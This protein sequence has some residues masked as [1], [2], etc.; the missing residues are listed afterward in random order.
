MDINAFLQRAQSARQ[1]PTLYLLGKGDYHPNASADRPGSRVDPASELALIQRQRPHIHAEYVKAMQKAG[2]ALEDLPREA[3]D[4]SGFVCW[5]LKIVRSTGPWTGGWIDTNNIHRD[6]RE[7]QALFRQLDR[8]V[9]GA[10]LVY[11]KPAGQGAD[12]PPGHVGIVTQ[13]DAQGRATRVLHC[14]PQNFLLTP[15]PGLPPSAIAETGP[16]VFDGAEKA[17]IAVMWKQFES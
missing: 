10:L 7:R 12:G 11:P 6:A 3:C 13:V 5:A 2:L 9:P 4:C 8:A 1:W 15:E 14:A 16:E 17:T